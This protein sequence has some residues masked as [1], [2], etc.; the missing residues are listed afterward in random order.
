[1]NDLPEFKYGGARALTL[2]HEKELR[3]FVDT[4][5]KARE[6]GVTLPPVK[7]PD[8]ESFE[9]I[10]H[11]VVFRTRDNMIWIC[12]Q[13]GLPDPQLDPVPE[14][15]ELANRVDDYLDRLL[16]Q[17]RTP[18]AEVPGRQFYFKTYTSAWKTD[19]CI[20]AMLEHMVMHPMRH[21]FQLENLMS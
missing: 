2:L 8:Y 12:Q 21:R 17:L 20:D 6:V 7:N 1:M 13:L 10:L 5:K 11:H 14:K 16:P 15:S 4:W 18:L 9:Q 3:C 19:Y